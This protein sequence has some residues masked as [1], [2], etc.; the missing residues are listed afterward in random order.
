MRQLSFETRV[1]LFDC[2][3]HSSSDM[4]N[5]KSTHTGTATLSSKQ[6][7]SSFLYSAKT[8]ENVFIDH[9]GIGTSK[10]LE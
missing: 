9:S 1:N 5:T 3:S 10:Q 2:G 4:S 7:L 6:R 8:K